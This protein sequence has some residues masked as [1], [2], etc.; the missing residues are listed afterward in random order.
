MLLSVLP[1]C[2]TV[3]WVVY[4]GEKDADQ[5]IVD[6]ITAI[7]KE[8]HEAGRAVGLEEVKKMGGENPI[9]D[10]GFGPKPKRTDLYCIMVSGF[11]R[12][13][14]AGFI[15]L[16]DMLNTIPESPPLVHLRIHWQTEGSH[17][18][19]RQHHLLTWVT[20]GVLLLTCHD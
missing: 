5:A 17:A 3:R 9:P 8:R 10:D 1:D 20:F 7:L 12:R 11:H 19:P 16:S 13:Q 2:P 4:D 14:K 15:A 6:K 18:V